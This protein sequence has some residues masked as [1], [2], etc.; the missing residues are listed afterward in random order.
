LPP[1]DQTRIRHMIEAAETACKF[2]SGRLR[3]DLDSDQM[4]VFAVVRAIEIVGEAAGKVSVQ[5]RQSATDVPWSLI[6]SMRNRVVHAYFDIDHE[7]VWKTATE[8]LPEVLP[9]LR[10]LI[11]EH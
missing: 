8:E 10:S 11:G 5:T 7:I 6:I 4:L 9:K 3:G 2:V 1:E